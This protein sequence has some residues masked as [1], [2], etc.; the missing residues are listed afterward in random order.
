MWRQLDTVEASNGLMEAYYEGAQRVEQL[1][2]AIPA[3]FARVRTVVG[4]PGLAV[5]ALEERLDWLGWVGGDD[6]GLQD[7][8]RESLLVDEAGMAHLDALIYGMSFVV[9]SAD[10]RGGVRVRA[11]SPRSATGLLEADGRT[12]RAGMIRTRRPQSPDRPDVSVWDVELLFPHAVV[13][14]VVRDGDGLPGRWDVVD[15]VAHRLGRVPMV[16]FPNRRRTS[17]QTGRSEITRAIRSIT[18]EAVRTMLGMATNREFY[19]FPQRWATNVAA[20][21]FANADGTPKPGW[22]IVMSSVWAVQNDD[23]QGQE[24]R[25]GQ[26]QPAS[27]APYVEQVEALS[28]LIG[29]EAALPPHYLGFVTANPASADA[30]RSTESRLVK[31]AERRQRSFG[32]AWLDVGRMV[33]EMGNGGVPDDFAR[34]VSC[35]WQ[36]A[37]TPTRA[38]SADAAMKLVSSG[39]LP[40]GSDVVLDMVGLSPE[41]Q[42]R[43]RADRELAGGDPLSALA[44]AIGRQAG[45]EPT[46]ATR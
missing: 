9:V 10:G 21:D 31:R 5:D 20:E 37:S 22:E 46:G 7:V 34:R 33:A 32:A 27:P 25:L 13:R 1:G 15:R 29:A 26:F 23:P 38:A 3:Q 28:Q 11:Q 4:W 36:D 44:A 42:E 12:L 6:L 41:E 16:A 40:A 14:C 43:V 35:R 18:D 39:I 8:F 30:I 2:V 24:P 17:R 19:S 45:P